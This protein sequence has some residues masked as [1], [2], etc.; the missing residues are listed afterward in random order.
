MLDSRDPDMTSS[1]SQR[2]DNLVEGTDMPQ[3]TT[4]WIKA[5]IKRLWEPREGTGFGLRIRE[6]FLGEDISKAGS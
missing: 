6:V 2:V 3:V 4:W 1:W 5:M